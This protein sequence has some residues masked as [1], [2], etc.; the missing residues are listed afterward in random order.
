MS[1]R[2]I[3][4]HFI[5]AKGLKNPHLQTL[6]QPL[7]RKVPRLNVRRERV[8]MPNEDFFEMD[9]VGQ[10]NGPIVIVLHGMAGSLDT[11]YASGIMQQDRKSVV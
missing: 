1:G 5:P 7:F 3:D 9:W 4:S 2:T 8:E 10:G 6:Y 11:G